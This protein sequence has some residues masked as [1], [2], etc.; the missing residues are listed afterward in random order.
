MNSLE[1]HSQRRTEEFKT[2]LGSLEEEVVVLLLTLSTEDMM[3][4][5]SC[6]VDDDMVVLNEECIHLLGLYTHLANKFTAAPLTI[7]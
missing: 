3:R 7:H 6:K 5:V 1:I 2:Y 4:K